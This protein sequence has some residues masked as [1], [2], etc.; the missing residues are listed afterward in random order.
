MSARNALQVG[1]DAEQTRGVLGGQALRLVNGGEPLDLGEEG[2][3][4]SDD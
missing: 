2:G 3:Q 4:K 1:L